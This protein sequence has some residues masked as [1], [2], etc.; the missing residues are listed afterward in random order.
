MKRSLK[1]LPALL[2]LLGVL[3]LAGCSAKVTVPNE[4][5]YQMRSDQ[6]VQMLVSM[7]AAALETEIDSLESHYEDFEQQV[8]L[9]PY[10]GGTGQK[11]DFTAEAYLSMLSSYAANL[12]EFGAYVGVKEYEGATEDSDGYLTYA[13]VY[14]V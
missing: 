7:D 10:I 11:F 12:D 2:A 4:A 8:A 14:E 3:V 9:Y 5:D 1:K 6:Y 13:T